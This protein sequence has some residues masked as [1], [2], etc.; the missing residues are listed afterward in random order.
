MTLYRPERETRFG[1]VRYQHVDATGTP[2][3]DG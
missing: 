3:D 2:I 1:R